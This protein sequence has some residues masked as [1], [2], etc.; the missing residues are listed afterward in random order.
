MK[1]R[2]LAPQ[3]E[4]PADI[5]HPCGGVVAE[6]DKGEIVGLCGFLPL[7]H[8]DPLWVREDYRGHPTLL[9]RLWDNTQSELSKA[10]IPVTLGFSR[11]GDTQVERIA[12]WAGGVEIPGRI[13]AF[14]RK[15]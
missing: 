13:F 3:D 10:D 15:D 6:N 1:Y 7:V 4:L 12:K 5:L 2:N 8:L 9:R 14:K 11:E